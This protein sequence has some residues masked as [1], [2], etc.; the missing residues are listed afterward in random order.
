MN[1]DKHGF[2]KNKLDLMANSEN[3]S[4]KNLICVIAK[5]ANIPLNQVNTN[6]FKNFASEINDKQIE[7]KTNNPNTSLKFD[8]QLDLN[9]GSDKK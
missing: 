2:L 5:N 7:T 8:S 1:S 6:F 9:L 3:I 4:G